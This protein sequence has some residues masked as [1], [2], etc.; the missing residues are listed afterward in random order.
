MAISAPI[1]VTFLLGVIYYKQIMWAYGPNNKL[2]T[3]ESAN[4]TDVVIWE[5]DVEF[6]HKI[7][8]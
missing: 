8:G 5:E 6:S 3:V 7:T 2:G 1:L 4:L